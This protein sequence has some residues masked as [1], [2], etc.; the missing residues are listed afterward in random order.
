MH[1]IRSFIAIPLD[2]GIQK[3]AT[4]LV[5]RLSQDKDGIKWVPT[6]NLH[7]TLKFL[8][9][10]DNVEI[11]RIC[12]LIQEA[13]DVIEPFTMT[14]TGIT[15]LPSLAK[16]RTIASS[17]DE[18][19]GTL[20]QLFNSLERKLA[21]IGFRPEPRDYV[22]HLTLG[23]IR[24]GS[25]RASQEVLERVE[26]EKELSLGFMAADTVQLMA[27]FLDKSG[28]TYQVMGTIEF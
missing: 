6:D 16:A 20:V 7:L 9:D 11:P 14:F 8:G 17:I 4:R 2:L 5:K 1:T 26:K 27:S 19:T 3:T 13:C 22:P 24:S 18:P 25:R 12:S 23:R 10:V 15:A 28:P 21:D